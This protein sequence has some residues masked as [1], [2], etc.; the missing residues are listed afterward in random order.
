MRAWLKSLGRSGSAAGHS[1]GGSSRRHPQSGIGDDRPELPPDAVAGMVPVPQGT[2]TS[3]GAGGAL[4]SKDDIEALRDELARQKEANAILEGVLAAM[5]RQVEEAEALADELAALRR[6]AGE[7]ASS[8]ATRG[9]LL[10]ALARA[11]RDG[12]RGRK[13][14]RRSLQVLR[15]EGGVDANWY[16]Y[17]NPDVAESGI[18]PALHYLLYGAYEG[19]DPNPHFS[20]LDYLR[21]YPEVWRSG[22]DPLTHSIRK[23]SKP[24]A[25][26]N[27]AA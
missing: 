5:R 18:D 21:R 23:R 9:G 20:T 6:L 19:R 10:G 8:R 14:M 1:L 4:P 11:V 25:N 16:R 12:I 17:R 13:R 2:A 27:A 24:G 7:M 3:P 26:P 22:V 15:G